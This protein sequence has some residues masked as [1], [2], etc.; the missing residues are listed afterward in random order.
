MN[1]HDQATQGHCSLALCTSSVLPWLASVTPYSH[2]WPSYILAPPAT[3]CSN[4]RSEHLHRIAHQRG[5]EGCV[6]P[7]GPG[8]QNE[9]TWNELPLWMV[10]SPLLSW[11]KDYHQVLLPALFLTQG[12]G[13]CCS[14]AL[15]W[16]DKASQLNHWCLCHPGST[17][18]IRDLGIGWGW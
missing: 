13:G 9:P 7:T 10:S 12:R 16:T 17:S 18:S 15:L 4:F 6:S 2:D 11:S 1:L 3:D 5:N 14:R 8:K